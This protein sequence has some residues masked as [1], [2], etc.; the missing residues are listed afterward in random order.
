MTPKQ[1]KKRRS[2]Q[3]I[4]E[5][6]GGMIAGFDQQIFRTLPP[7]HELVQKG[8]PVRGLSGDP[9]GDDQDPEALVVVLPARAEDADP[10]P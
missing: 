9:A 8:A 5:A 6:L 1:G 7:P 4:G 2:G 3:P 10:T